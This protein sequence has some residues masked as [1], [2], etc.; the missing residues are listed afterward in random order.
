MMMATDAISF[1]VAFYLFRAGRAVPEVMF[2]PTSPARQEP[3]DIFVI[4]AGL[5]ILVRYLAGD[6]S[7]RRLFWDNAHSTTVSLIM[8][9]LPG[10]LIVFSMPD[11]Y[12]RM[13][14]VA[15]WAF[16]LFAIPMARQAMRIILNYVGIWR[17]P[18]ALIA[19]GSRACDVFSTLNATLSLGWDIR[20]VAFSGDDCRA[21]DAALHLKHLYL[22]DP[23]DIARNLIADGCG[24]A[25]VAT[26]DMQSPRFAEL[27]QRLM[28]VGLSVSFIP[29]FRRLPLVGVTTSFFFGKDILMFQVRSALQRFPNRVAKRFFDITG[30]LALLIVFSPAI[31]FICCAIKLHDGGPLIYGQRRTGQRGR[32]FRCLKFRTMRVDADECL[33]QWKKDNPKLYEEFLKSYKLPN[34]PRITRPGKW[35]RRTSL[36]ELP[37]LVNVLRG[38]MSL[39]GPRPIPEAQLRDQY[40]TAAELYKQ[41]RP[42]LTGLWQVSGRNETSLDDRVN[43][44][45]WYILNWSMWYDIV[46]LLQTI[47]IVLTGRGAY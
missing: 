19:S 34:D 25:V 3:L 42:G 39:V 10:L 16:L 2:L 13:A 33:E 26:D 46:I 7:R 17:Q 1:T 14:E 31:A 21:P 40:G 6:Y 30:S 15:S 18:T 28:E 43:Y 29:S 35:L 36:D 41:V 38:E 37:Q 12:S 5:F 45:E 4:F 8:A 27:I 20:W 44:D 9:S 47:L 24:Q 11:Q 23:R 22:S 32:Q